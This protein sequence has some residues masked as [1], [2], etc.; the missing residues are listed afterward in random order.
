[1]KSLW[2]K[3]LALFAALAAVL[4]AAEPLN[5][6]VIPKGTTHEFWKAINAGAI[7]AQRELAASG[8]AVNVIWK[9]LAQ[10][11]RPRQQVQVVENFIGR[12]V[13]AS[14]WPARHKALQMT[15][16]ATPEAQARAGP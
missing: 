1:M 12:R 14:C 2:F 9:G 6:A 8:V 13:S 16:T 4:P 10:G 11:G 3:S 5:I 15:F 7:K